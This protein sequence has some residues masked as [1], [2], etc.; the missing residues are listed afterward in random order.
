MPNYYPIMLDVRGRL[1]IVVGGDDVA[2]QKARSLADCGAQ[3]TL[4]AESLCPEAQELI[5]QGHARYR[6]KTYEP[7]DLA[8]A[9]LVFAA[10]THQPEL[11]DAIW[12]ES[13]ERGLLLNIVDVPAKCDFIMPSILRQ[14]QLTIAVST[15]GASPS[16]AKRIRQQ[17][18]ESFPPA[19]DLYLRLAATARSYLRDHQVTYDQRDA[20][21]GEY[22]VS[23][24]LAQ[25]EAHDIVRATQTTAALLHKYDID[26]SSTQ[27]V[28]V[29]TDDARE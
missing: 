6:Q 25:L 29:V 8:G 15:E 23:P 24:V 7:G 5:Q 21:F 1:V 22:F 12:R 19:Y 10:V 28:E 18:E 26:I 14:G 3:V 13:R 9:Y 4:L 16:L 20:F 17:L 27:L 11:V 2:A